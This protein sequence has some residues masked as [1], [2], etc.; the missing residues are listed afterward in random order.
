TRLDRVADAVVNLASGSLFLALHI[1]WFAVW[2]VMNLRQSSFDPYPFSLLT[3]IVSLEAIILTGFV[4]MAQRRM[5]MQ[6]DKRAH[7]D[8]QSTLLAEQELT[9]ILRLLAAL[10]KHAGIDPAAS[11]VRLEQFIAATDIRRLSDELDR[12]LAAVAAANA[13]RSESD[14]TPEPT[15]P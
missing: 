5:T 13:E 14:A 15:A 6:A 3:L 4:L 2:I 8:L 9:A 11:G 7:H 12:E 1:V 10:T